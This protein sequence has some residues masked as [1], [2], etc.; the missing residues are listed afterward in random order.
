MKNRDSESRIATSGACS[1]NSVSLDATFYLPFVA[2]SDD[3]G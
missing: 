1:Q 3:W 2:L